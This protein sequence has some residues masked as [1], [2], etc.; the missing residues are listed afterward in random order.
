MVWVE[1]PTNPLM[2]LADIAAVQIT[3]ANNILFAVDN[4]LQHRICRI[5]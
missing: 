1:T 5:R 3:K 4:T 2:K